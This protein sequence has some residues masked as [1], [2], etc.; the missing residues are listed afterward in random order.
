[1]IWCSDR[2]K[3]YFFISKVW[4]MTKKCLKM[5]FFP[6]KNQKFAGACRWVSYIPKCALNYDWLHGKGLILRTLENSSQGDA[7][8]WKNGKI[9][10]KKKKKTNVLRRVRTLTPCSNQYWS[11]SLCLLSYWG[12]WLMGGKIL[13]LI[14]YKFCVKSIYLALF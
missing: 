4:K 2:K 13:K 14:A 11:H 1:M 9:G 5:M 7:K 6:I 12:I 10:G 3:K 8:N